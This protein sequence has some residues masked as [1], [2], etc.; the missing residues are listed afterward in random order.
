MTTPY[1]DLPTFTD[2]D[3]FTPTDDARTSKER[4]VAAIRSAAA[5]IFSAS[6][7]DAHGA[8]GPVAGIGAV[9]ISRGIGS[10]SARSRRQMSRPLILGSMRSRM[11]SVYF[12]FRSI[13][14]AVSPSRATSTQT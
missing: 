14:R 6:V 10:P 5:T 12:V 9:S 2:T 1:R 13:S 11:A 8:A 3:D 4:I 7:A